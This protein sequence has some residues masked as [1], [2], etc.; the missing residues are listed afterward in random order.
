MLECFECI[1]KHGRPGCPAT[2][3]SD[4]GKPVCAWCTDGEPCPVEQRRLKASKKNKSGTPPAATE[5]AKPANEPE[6]EGK[7]MENI[8]SDA[9]KICKRPGCKV[10]LSSA[11]VSGLCR[12]HVRWRD[13]PSSDDG[14]AIAVTSPANGVE[15]RGN[16][17]GKPANGHAIGDDQVTS[18]PKNGSNGAAAGLPQ[19]AADRVDQLLAS[20]TAG[21]K[22]KLALAWLR[23]EL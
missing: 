1:A 7:A 14:P 21:D 8:E 16:G 4:E 19:L 18:A 17:V 3:E 13:R 2:L 10:A 11:N 20:L 15:K 23:G 5:S 9:P 12:A 22:A 6:D